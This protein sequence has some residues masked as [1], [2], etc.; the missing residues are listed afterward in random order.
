MTRADLCWLFATLALCACAPERDVELAGSTRFVST[1]TRISALSQAYDSAALPAQV[2]FGGSHGRSALYLQF[3]T[4]F[5]G[6]GTPVKA[7]ITLSARAD[8][9]PDAAP[10]V[11]EAWRVNAPWQPAELRAWSDKPPLAPPFAN[12]KTS[13]SPARALRIDVT[14]LV[15]FAAQNPAQDFGIALLARGGS[16]HGV[17]FATGI[18]AGDAP[19]L[20]VYLR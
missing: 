20:E 9:S 6:R 5:A 15:R 7:F 17:S 19:R 12:E 3:P 18:S 14:E 10:V 16:G 8:A 13:A 4:D 2:T 1:P 11:V